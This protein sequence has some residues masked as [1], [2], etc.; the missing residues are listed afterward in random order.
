MSTRNGQQTKEVALIINLRSRSGLGAAQ[1]AAR[2]LKR[3]GLQV[4]ESHLIKTGRGVVKAARSAIAHG[5]RTIVVGGG[6]G[7][8]SA[9]VDLLANRPDLALGVLPIGTGNEVA[10]VLGI[11]LDLVPAVEV[12]AHGRVEEV[13]LAHANGDYFM[14]TAIVGYPAF[15]NFSTPRELKRRFGR[16]AYVAFF[17]ASMKK[18]KPF[19]AVVTAGSKHWEIETVVAI[20]GNGRFHVPARVLL[21]PSKRPASGLIVYTPKDYRLSTLLRLAA[22]LWITHQQQP[23]LIV[24]SVADSIKLA[25]N[26]PQAV[27][28]DGEYGGTTPI[29]FH[30]ARKA[31][32]VLVP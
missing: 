7:T 5:I 26:P 32:R 21:P 27:D 4:K 10:R 22:G 1:V 16:L 29:E 23:S 14:H 3:H 17:L 25:T 13:D 28:L 12:V 30:A 20:I 15:I 19:R 18:I 2:E 31:L 11:P 9:A 6:D 24:C 8:I